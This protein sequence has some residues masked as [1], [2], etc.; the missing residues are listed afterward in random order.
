M[1]VGCIVA[2][3]SVDTTLEFGTDKVDIDVR[4]NDIRAYAG[5]DLSQLRTFSEY[6]QW[7]AAWVE[8]LPW[9]PTPDRYEFTVDA[10]KLNLQMHGTMTRLQFDR[11][12]RPGS[13]DGGVRPCPNFPFEMTGT[14]YA[15]STEVKQYKAIVLDPASPL[16][17]PFD[18]KR[19]AVRF[20][21][22][23]DEAEFAENGPSLAR[24][25]ELFVPTPLKAAEALRQIEANEALFVR[26]T[27]AAWSAQLAELATC[28][29]QPWCD[30]RI[31]AARREE[32][33][34]VFEY[35]R[36]S[37][38]AGA[39]VKAPVEMGFDF[40]GR[41]Y[42]TRL[43]K[44]R[45]TNIDELRLRIL[46]DMQLDAFREQGKFPAQS[47]DSVCRPDSMKKPSL[48]DFCLLIGS[49]PPRK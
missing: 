41:T 3:H 34:L 12:V 29:E 28:T 2:P 7:K 17:W 14:G 40:R 26:G 49:K 23:K 21:V 22:A 13:G 20:T 18:N 42:V 46:Y 19:I 11:C 47:W 36:S 15:V 24:G 38:E 5:D 43:P 31:E 25:Y 35:L 27:S 32:A 6:V 48:K 45:L 37:P 44:D 16:A 10:G 30:L 9:A 39:R 8:E 33:H 4:L 1:T